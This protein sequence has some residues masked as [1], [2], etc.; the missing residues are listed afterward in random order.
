M[1]G[2]LR[3]QLNGT[4]LRV[5]IV[6]AGW[7]RVYTESLTKWCRQALLDAGTPAT[8]IVEILVPGSYELP[9]GCQN[10]IKTGELDAV[11]AIGVLIKGDTVHF[12]Y[13]AEAVTHGLMQVGLNNNRP[14]IFG[15]LTCL[16][17]E[18]AIERC[19]DTDKNKGYE[20]GL[21]AL[22]MGLIRQ[23]ALK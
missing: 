14:V 19:P 9:W 10:A 21:A 17:E 4:N 23:G 7:N 12:E 11:V 16:N 6:T 20:F 2:A 8:N 13:I 15:V 18:Q 22:R 5:A 1:K 3:E